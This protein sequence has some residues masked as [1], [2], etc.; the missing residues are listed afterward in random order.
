MVMTKM[1]PVITNKAPEVCCSG[2]FS[3]MQ[4]ALALLVMSALLVVV[5]PLYFSMVDEAR[6][7]RLKAVK[8]GF[9]S[10]V[11]RSREKWLVAGTP[12]YLETYGDLAMSKAGWPQ[13][14]QR[15]VI[16]ETISTSGCVQLW[17][18]LLIDSAPQVSELLMMDESDAA[19]DAEAQNSLIEALRASADNGSA[20]F[21]AIAEQGRCRYYMSHAGQQN[22]NGNIRLIEYDP[23]NGRV[24]WRIL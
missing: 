4:I 9:H 10:A 8:T 22:L 6:D 12:G 7:A 20:E 21:Y 3:L 24:I 15:Q 23:N 18:Q 14:A 19:E 11:L 5:L 1:K 16:S 13:P 17:Q 2:G